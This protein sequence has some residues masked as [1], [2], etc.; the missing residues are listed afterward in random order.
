MTLVVIQKY[1]KPNPITE[2]TIWESSKGILHGT[3]PKGQ[4]KNHTLC[5]IY[6]YKGWNYRGIGTPTCLHCLKKI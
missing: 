6:L 4:R 5:G 2:F 3:P 1:E